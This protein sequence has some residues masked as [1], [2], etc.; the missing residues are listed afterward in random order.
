MSSSDL[1]KLQNKLTMPISDFQSEFFISK[2]IRIFRKKFSLKNTIKGQKSKK[3]GAKSLLPK[4]TFCASVP[5]QALPA[6]S[7]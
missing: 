7:N 3:T 1:P 4:Y 2:I 5:S 6:G